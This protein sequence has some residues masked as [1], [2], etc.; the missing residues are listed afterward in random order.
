M[1]LKKKVNFG[2]RGNSETTPITVLQAGCET[3]RHAE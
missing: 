2:F 3:F 1:F